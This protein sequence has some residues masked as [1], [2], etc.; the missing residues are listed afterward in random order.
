MRVDREIR[1]SPCNFEIPEK[2][3]QTYKMYT[4]NSRELL[5]RWDKKIP[6]I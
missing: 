6:T 5:I 1:I 3:E 4:Q 2:S